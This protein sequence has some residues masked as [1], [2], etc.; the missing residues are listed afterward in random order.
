MSRLNGFGKCRA[1]FYVQWGDVYISGT[2]HNITLTFSMLTNLTHMNTLSEYYH[3][4]VN[5]DQ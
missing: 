1:S 4:S 5:I 3:A 2:E